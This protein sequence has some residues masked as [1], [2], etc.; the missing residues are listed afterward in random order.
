MDN[1]FSESQIAG[2][3]KQLHDRIHWLLIYKDNGD[4]KELD[5]YFNELLR[6]IKSLNAVF[7]YQP[8]IIQLLVTIES[9]YEEFKKPNCDFKIYRKLVL[10]AHALIDKIKE[11]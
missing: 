7:N 5:K 3:K 4:S 11:V 8:V 1:N 2:Y 10:D 6:Q 9:A